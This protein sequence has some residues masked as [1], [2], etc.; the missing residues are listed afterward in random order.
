MFDLNR[1]K[2]VVIAVGVLV[3][4]V[5]SAQT[6]PDLICQTV[7]E[8][9]V[10]HAET[11]P[12]RHSRTPDLYRIS[13]GRIYMSSPG[14]DEYLYGDVIVVEPGRF[15]AGYKTFVFSIGDYESMVEVHTDNQGTRV[16]RLHCV[17]TG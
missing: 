9:T 6:I 13:E 5:G 12:T 8:V 16:R 4:N 15:T 7:E 2:V 17:R 3:A 10:T 1:Q 14:T 11:L